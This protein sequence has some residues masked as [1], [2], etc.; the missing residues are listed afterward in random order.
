MWLR[1]WPSP[2]PASLCPM[3]LAVLW[4]ELLAAKL[5]CL[6]REKQ[7]RQILQ[8]AGWLGRCNLSLS[9]GLLDTWLLG[10]LLGALDCGH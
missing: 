3:P 4:A 5:L 1:Q 8:S 7:G 6:P 9:P 10:P 2:W